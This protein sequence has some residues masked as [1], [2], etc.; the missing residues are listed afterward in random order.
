MRWL[1]RSG[2]KRF[3]SSRSPGARY[4]EVEVF[5]ESAL[6]ELLSS[7]NFRQ[8]S[9]RRSKLRQAEIPLTTRLRDAS[10]ARCA[11]DGAAS[12]EYTLSRLQRVPTFGQS[13]EKLTH[14]AA[15]TSPTD[16]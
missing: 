16:Q 14:G 15:V 5:S 6:V 3:Q 9:L 1:T 8:E 12:Q 7:G 2:R 13:N 4:L 11:S 10:V